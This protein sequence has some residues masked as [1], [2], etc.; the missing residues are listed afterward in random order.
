MGTHTPQEQAF[1]SSLEAILEAAKA[2]GIKMKELAARNGITPETLSRMRRR[3]SGD[4]GVL[5][6]MAVMVGLRFQLVPDNAI[7]DAI[8]NGTLF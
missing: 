1:I 8:N 5:A 6:T 7:L 4:F 2:R 3:G